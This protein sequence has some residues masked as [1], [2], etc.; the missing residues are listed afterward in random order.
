M[1]GREA[2]GRAGAMGDMAEAMGEGMVAVVARGARGAI[3]GWQR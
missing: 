2:V 1:G 3:L